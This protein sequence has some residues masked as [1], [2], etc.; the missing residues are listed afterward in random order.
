MNHFTGISLYKYPVMR[1]K[2]SDWPVCQ[3]IGKKSHPPKKGCF[4][5]T[6][7]FI[8]EPAVR[9]IFHCKHQPRR[10]VQMSNETAVTL[11]K[12][13]AIYSNIKQ[14]KLNTCCLLDV[15]HDSP[16]SE[17]L[18]DRGRDSG[19]PPSEIQLFIFQTWLRHV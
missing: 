7:R 1:R 8:A 13:G 17:G 15:I 12:A 14:T 3:S 10:K 16:C 2:R 9:D 11:Y 6:S 19:L 4:M 5:R 18:S